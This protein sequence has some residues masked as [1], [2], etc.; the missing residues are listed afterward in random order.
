M[1]TL[2]DGNFHR[3]REPVELLAPPAWVQ[4][5]KTGPLLPHG[6]Q[7]DSF[8][9][10]VAMANIARHAF[11]GDPLFNDADKHFLR[12]QEFLNIMAPISNQIPELTSTPPDDE[13]LPG[14]F[15]PSN[16]QMTDPDPGS[17]LEYVDHDTGTI[18]EP[19]SS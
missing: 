12:I 16:S 15:F 7:L 9:C 13:V 14:E 17:D 8:S 3:G 18:S 19:D 11:F 5:F 1:V 2:L 10:S 4:A 6:K